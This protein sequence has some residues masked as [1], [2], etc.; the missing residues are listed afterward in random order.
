MDD[1][2]SSTSSKEDNTNSRILQRRLTNCP[3]SK[4]LDNYSTRIN[5]SKIKKHCVKTA[6]EKYWN[7]GAGAFYNPRTRNFDDRRKRRNEE[8]LTRT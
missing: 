1:D 4:Y 3:I 6:L 7:F 8:S 2:L 5:S